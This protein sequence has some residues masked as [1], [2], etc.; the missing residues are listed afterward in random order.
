[1]ALQSKLLI[2]RNK[3]QGRLPGK[4]SN[5]FK[6]YL[7]DLQ[8]FNYWLTAKNLNDNQPVFDSNTC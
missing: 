4:K 8:L 5:W 1:V 7:S 2:G 3:P 6:K